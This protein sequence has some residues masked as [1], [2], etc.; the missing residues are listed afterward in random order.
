MNGLQCNCA[1]KLQE[2][3]LKDCGSLN[4]IAFRL[5]WLAGT[6]GLGAALSIVLKWHIT[7]ATE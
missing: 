3:N 2:I 6:K 1:N 4:I 5:V 7:S